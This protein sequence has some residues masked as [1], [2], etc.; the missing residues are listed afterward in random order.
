MCE[1]CVF[2]LLSVCIFSITYVEISHSCAERHDK[3]VR[4]TKNREYLNEVSPLL[5]RF[6]YVH[7]AHIT[8]NFSPP[9]T[10][11]DLK[12]GLSECAKY[13]YE[14]DNNMYVYLGSGE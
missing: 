10:S 9:T 14:Q 12:L 13:M 6:D 2:E 3:N 7:G 4:R 1:P 5:H 11:G 8:L